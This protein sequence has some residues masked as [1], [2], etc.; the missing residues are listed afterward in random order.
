MLR[1]DI[2]F[3]P[4]LIATSF[5][6]TVFIIA[7]LT[8]KIVDR[9]VTPN[10]LLYYFLIEAIATAQMC[11]CVYENAVIVRH[12]GPAGF[13]FTVTSLLFAGSFVNRGAFVSPLKPVEL[14]Y[15]GS[16]G[17]DR[18]LTVLA[19]ETLGGYSAYRVARRL[20]YWSLS[21]AAD[22]AISYETTRCA[23]AYKVPF[24]YAFAFEILGSFLM[25]SIHTRL[26]LNSTRYAAPAITSAFL[27]FSL[28]FIGVVGL[29]P[30]VSS[31]RMQGC[32]GLSTQWFILTYW[33]CPTVGWMLSAIVDS[34]AKE[35]MVKKEK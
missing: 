16:I 1:I 28:A 21:L 34:K 19:A 26:P 24:V 25:R 13:F 10:T 27:T 20:W 7:E 29:N 30:T 15:F 22:H 2:D 33:V 4:L 23:F 14:F 35:Q 6:S 11:T 18:L 17:L 31:S 9:Y 12:Y 8:R 5:Y 3:G 32:D